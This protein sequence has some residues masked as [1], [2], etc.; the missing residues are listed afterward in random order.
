MNF[1]EQ[2]LRLGTVLFSAYYISVW[3]K[4]RCEVSAKVRMRIAFETVDQYPKAQS[5][6]S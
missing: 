1:I 5:D 4:L 6:L 2:R 3:D